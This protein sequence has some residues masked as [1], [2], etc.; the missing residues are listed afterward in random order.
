MNVDDRGDIIENSLTK[1]EDYQGLTKELQKKLEWF[2]DQKVGIIFHWGLYSQAGIVESWQL[3]KEDTWA[4]KKG[5]WRKDLQMLRNDYWNLANYFNPT[6]FDPVDWAEKAKA[7]GFKYMLFTTKHHD[8][9]NMY[10]TKY[11]NYKITSTES[12]FSKNDKADILMNVNEA[13]RAAGLSTGAYFSKA[14]WHSPDYWEPGSD[15]Q[16]RYASYDPKENVQRWQS[17]NLFVENQLLEICQNYGPIDILWLDGGWVNSENNELLDMDRIVNKIRK[18][19]SDTIVVD[20]SIGGKYENYVTPEREIPAVPPRKAWESNIP[21]A[22][23][24]GYV[25]NDKYKSFKSILDSLVEI[26]CLGGNIILGVGPKPDGTLPQ[27]AEQIMTQL[28]EWLSAFGEAVYDTRPYKN[29]TNFK[30]N[31]TQKGKYKYLFFKKNENGKKINCKG[32]N[33]KIVSIVN[34]ENDEKVLVDD[35]IF[36]LPQTGY[37]YGALRFDLKE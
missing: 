28:G 3:S 20:R 1:Q 25:P 35:N 34:L 11:S 37:E 14:D 26:I 7:A 32:L 13:F 36:T 33:K 15:P 9:F 30:V 29:S 22:K 4:R 19:K 21:L 16:G 31:M 18:I 23:N 24:W 17:F 2:K 5:A 27:E 8:G 12:P 10:D 6:K